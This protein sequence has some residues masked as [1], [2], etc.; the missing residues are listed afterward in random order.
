MYT[1]VPKK[2]LGRTLLILEKYI[3]ICS[4][5]YDFLLV[6]SLS[7]M[8]IFTRAFQRVCVCFY[9]LIY[10]F[11]VYGSSFISWT[12]IN[13]CFIKLS[14]TQ[15]NRKYKAFPFTWLCMISFEWFFILSHFWHCLIFN[16]NVVRTEVGIWY[17]FNILH[18]YKESSHNFFMYF[19]IVN[20]TVLDF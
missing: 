16:F 8:S 4:C 10:Y 1:T 14:L 13:S 5:I 9:Y 12:S 19:F 18:I 6:F 11:R 20:Q 7:I 15:T 3:L 17:I 2:A